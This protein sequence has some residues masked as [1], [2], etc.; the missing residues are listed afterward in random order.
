[1]WFFVTV[2][3]PSAK[4]FFFNATNK[5]SRG[6]SPATHSSSTEEARR[7]HSSCP[8]AQAARPAPGAVFTAGGS[9]RGARPQ[10][11]AGRSGRPPAPA[12]LSPPAGRGAAVQPPPRQP[13][14]ASGRALPAQLTAAAA[15]QRGAQ[16]ASRPLPPHARRRRPG[17]RQQLRADP[18]SCRCLRLG[19][20]PP[21]RHRAAAGGA[22]RARRAARR[23]P[24]PG[25]GGPR[26]PGLG[27]PRR[28]WARGAGLAALSCGG[29]RPL[30]ADSQHSLIWK[31]KG[32]T[33]IIASSSWP[34]ASPS[35]R[36]AP[37]LEMETHLELCQVPLGG[38][39]REERSRCRA[40]S[41][42]PCPAAAR[43]PG[44]QPGLLAPSL[45]LKLRRGEAKGLAP[46][47]V[48]DRSGLVQPGKQA[49]RLCC[50]LP[51]QCLQFGKLTQTCCS[52]TGNFF[53]EEKRKK[54]QNKNILMPLKHNYL[55]CH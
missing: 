43:Q 40:G 14:P 23:A 13:R 7:P 32:H 47:R 20:P 18:R 34:Y 4:R 24:G 38:C 36:V 50:G 29:G 12:G 26:R 6:S 30:V 33:R 9:Q 28:P 22:G 54:L 15:V 46:V 27:G 51:A 49:V 55:I 53:Q 5:Y 17:T 42:A 52:D 31:G 21:P 1:M 10:R 2:S 39:R 41:A 45:K 44:G 19:G 37:V 3:P 16:A 8:T 48:R 11:P 35:P 25:R